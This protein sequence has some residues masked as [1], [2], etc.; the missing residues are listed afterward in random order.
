MIEIYLFD[1]GDTLMVDFAGVPGKMC[2]WD[3]VEVVD[4]ARETLK[5]LSKTSKI[6]VATGAAQSTETEIQQ[7]FERVDLNPFISGYFC[8]AN[9]GCT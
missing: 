2:D 5:C 9:L 3:V 1:W 7:A 4:G 6:Y 8:E